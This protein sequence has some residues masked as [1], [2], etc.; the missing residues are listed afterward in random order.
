MSIFSPDGR[1]KVSDTKSFPFAAVGKMRIHWKGPDGVIDTADDII[2]NG[3]GA[4]ISPYHFLT[5]GH[6][7]YDTRYGGWADKIEVMLGSKGNIIAGTN[8]ADYEYY[9]E[10]KSVYT[11]SFEGWTQGDQTKSETFQYDIGLVTLDR[12]IGNFTGWFNYGYDDNLTSGTLMNV[13]GYPSDKFDSNSDRKFDNY[14][15]WT[16]SGKITSTTDSILRSNELDILPGNSGGPLW[17]NNSNTNKP[18]IY[19]VASNETTTNQTPLYNE[20]ARITSTRYNEIQTWIDEDTTTR[21]PT[22]KADLVDSDVWFNTTLG[23]FSNNTIKNGENFSITVYPRNNGTAATGNFSAS[24]YASTD[25]N[26]TNNIGSHYLIGNTTISSINPF[27]SGTA[28]WNGAF[29][30]IPIGNY[31]VI[32]FLDPTN[33]IQ[34]FDESLT[35]NQKVFRTLLTVTNSAPISTS[36][37]VSST[38]SSPL[39]ARE[40]NLTTGT[41]NINGTGNNQLN[42]GNSNDILIGGSGNDTF[43]GGLGNDTLT[44]GTGSDVFIINTLSEGIDNIRDFSTLDDTIY[45]SKIGFGGGLSE[46]I[47]QATQFFIGSV[48]QDSSDR[49]IYNNNTGGLFFDADGTGSSGQIQA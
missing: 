25:A 43:V 40:E 19:G 31:Y 30:N 9:G 28:T 8:R 36:L 15:M 23:S 35:S 42:G 29:P 21:K 12:N 4:M 32:S 7:V 37:T 26:I 49:F 48:A 6:S 2:L 45:V 27:N 5:A 3:S 22:D 47:L 33:S 46:G 44:G 34:E 14:D 17:L 41:A 38:V 13:T 16:Q 1:T 39:T 11:R 20:F 24:F 18:T 10:A